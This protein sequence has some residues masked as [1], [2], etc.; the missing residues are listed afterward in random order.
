MR[1]FVVPSAD[2]EPT[3]T[4]VPDPTPGPGEVL[5]RVATSSL[6]GFDLSVAAG[7]LQGMMEH[8]FPVVLGKDF[9]GTVEA[10]GE[11]VTR[12]APGDAVLGVVTKAHLG[13]GGFGELL[14]VHEGDFITAVPEG[15]DLRSAGALG[16]AG[17]AALD[18][19]NAAGVQ[20]GQTVL[21]SG[22]TG[23]VGAL[24]VQYAAAA[25]A[26]VI[27]T[28]RRGEEADLVTELGAQHT[29]DYTGDVAAQVRAIA[30][31]GVGAI[32]HLAGDGAELAGLLKPGGKIGSTMGY[33]PEQ[34]PAATFVMANPSA[35]TLARLA[36]DA[37]AGRIRVPITVTYS[38]DDVPRA[39]EDFRSGTRGKIC[40]EIG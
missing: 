32:V 25:G 24:A 35:D 15:L 33:G 19:L 1:A 22:A 11:G 18:T 39:F 27:A 34:N 4:E 9:A 2:A 31:E 3:V 28:A 7:Y 23:G 13:D 38:L 26:T 17:T 40:I 30:P 14:V 37:A 36:A 5:V 29:V 16:L 6:N 21:V 8:R 10:V 20:A 12:F